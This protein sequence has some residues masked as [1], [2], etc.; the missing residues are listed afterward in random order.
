[1][2]SIKKL[3]AQ[4]AV[5]GLSS[6]LGRILT[7]LLV[8]LYTRVF[9]PAEYGVVNEIYAY[10]SVFLVLL[11]YGFETGYF[12]FVELEV[13]KQKVY[14]TAL[15]SLIITSLAFIVIA[16]VF[17]KPVAVALRYPK[18]SEYIL[19]FAIIV[20]FDA[21]SAIPFARLRS[22]NKAKRFAVIKLI[23][24]FFNVALNLFFILL[25]P[26]LL[27]KGIAVGFISTVYNPEIGVGYVFLS[28]LISSGITL[29]C[30]IPEMT[31][32]H[33]HFDKQLWSRMIKYSLPLLVVGLAGIINE[34]MDRVF[35]KFL[36]PADISLAQV[37]IYGACYKISII[38]SLF[39]QAF[40]FAADP[41][42][43]SH[44]KQENA[45]QIYADVMTY[46]TIIC[47]MI[48]LA[49]M[50]Y[51]DVVKYLI[52]K[53]YYEGLTIVPVLLAANMCLGVYVNLSIWYKLT[54]QTRFGAILSV[55]GALITIGLNIW[56]I[57]I[58]GYVGSAWTTLICYAF[59][60]IASYFWGQKYYHIKYNLL[61]IF[62]YF[63]LSF[64]LYFL[65]TYII[66]DNQT[67]HLIINSG[68]MIAF[69]IYVYVN[70]KKPLQH[71]V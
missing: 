13:D 45:K 21:L 53:N 47:S 14:S 3:A 36:L 26:Y 35:L 34:T 20:S 17:S 66:V 50:L 37:G 44:A 49:V 1:L 19:W 15:I 54:G 18:H 23:N 4:T 30:L 58:M 57:P 22:Q 70:E 24:I 64:G 60:M 42:F 38:M 63:A 2:S 52:G 8:P 25:C 9:L 31:G 5:Y 12:R 33:Y 43:F 68:L 51:I 59:M 32:I 67:L 40:R 16:L 69:L 29:I 56:L 61:K 10:I 6:I 71:L 62:R 27:K 48:F 11:T 41:F 28:N 46:F 55:A 39:I 65:S 7:Y